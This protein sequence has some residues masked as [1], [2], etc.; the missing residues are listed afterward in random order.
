MRHLIRFLV[1]RAAY[2]IQE[3]SYAPDDFRMWRKRRKRDRTFR[4]KMNAILKKAN[5]KL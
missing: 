2:Y 3:I 5:I 4:K 1:A